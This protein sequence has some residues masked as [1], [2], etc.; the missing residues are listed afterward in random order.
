[1]YPLPPYRAG[2]SAPDWRMLP[3]AVAATSNMSR[4][5]ALSVL[6]KYTCA[7]DPILH[8]VYDYW[9]AKR[10]RLN[11]PIMRRLQVGPR[12]TPTSTCTPRGA[13]RC[14]ALALS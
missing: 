3:A 14:G 2:C 13:R 4:D 9:R 12:S 6:R 8:A 7:R 5:E 11:R 1:M 10:E